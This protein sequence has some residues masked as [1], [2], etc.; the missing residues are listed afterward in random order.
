MITIS[1]ENYNSITQEFYDSVIDSLQFQQLQC[2]CRR[3]GSFTIHG[4]YYRGVCT[5]DCVCMLHVCRVRCS[6]CGATHSLLLSSIVPY[7]RVPVIVQQEVAQAFDAGTDR[8]AVCGKYLTVD[9]NQVKAIIRRYVRHWCQRLLS[10]SIPLA[11]LSELPGR[12]LSVYSAQFM[13]I[14]RTFN[15][16]FPNTT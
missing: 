4:Y 9:E 3:F 12:C 16:L 1:V 5:P 6:E 8:N 10:E 15:V 11:P 13:Q 2:S 14:H 7:S